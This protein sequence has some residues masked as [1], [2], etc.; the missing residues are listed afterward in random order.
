MPLFW[1]VHEIDGKRRIWIQEAGALNH[2]ADQSVDR[3]V[4]R[5]Y[6]R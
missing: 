4:R 1:L 5:G 2:C 6:V 3:R